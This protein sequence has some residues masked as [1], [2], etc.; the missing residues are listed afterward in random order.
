MQL[1]VT[2]VGNAGQIHDH[3]L[4]AETEARVTAGTVAAQIE[5][6]PVILLVEAELGHARGEQVEPLLALRAADDLADAGSGAY[7]TP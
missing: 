5:I 1:H 3:A 7:R 6:P 2:D 4:K